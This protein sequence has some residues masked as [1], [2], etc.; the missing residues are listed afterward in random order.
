MVKII[1]RLFFTVLLAVFMFSCTAIQTQTGVEKQLK[2]V[3]MSSDELRLRLNEYAV[4]FSGEVV[5]A[6][7]KIKKNTNDINV[8]QN[9]LLWKMNSIPAANKVLFTIDPFAAVL[10]MLAFNRQ[11]YNFFNDGNGK[12]LFGNKQNIAIETS[13]NLEHDMVKILFQGMI[14]TTKGDSL[15]LIFEFADKHPFENLTF[16]RNSTINFFA[17]YMADTDRTITSSVGNMETA[18]SELSMRL[19]IYYDQLPKIASWNVEYL[20]NQAKLSGEADTLLNSFQLMSN[21]LDRIAAV[22]EKIDFLIDENIQQSFQ[23]LEDMRQ[24]MILDLQNE[25][26]L[27]KQLVESERKIILVEVNNQRRETIAELN[28]LSDKILDETPEKIESMV[29]YIFW[30]LLL[31]LAIIYIVLLSTYFIIAKT[32]KQE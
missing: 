30:R 2:N 9:A 3:K 25:R 28:L 22:S 17:E 15:L 21:S 29:D 16:S 14:D 32:R 26:E 13:K 8:K 20:V 4:R 24:R 11:M 5:S 19:N 23:N 12:D 27:F 31:I 18:I 10:D 6:A 7:D 1:F